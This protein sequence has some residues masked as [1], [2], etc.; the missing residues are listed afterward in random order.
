ME[1]S[2]KSISKRTVAMALVAG[3][4]LMGLATTANA[5]SYEVKSGDTLSS[6][7]VAHDTSIDKLLQTN[8]KNVN[9]VLYVGD[10]LTINNDNETADTY[11]I[12]SGDSLS[13]IAHDHNMT[14]VDLLSVNPTLSAT[15]LILPGQVI[16]LTSNSSVQATAPATTTVD[17]ASAIVDNAPVAQAVTTQAVE[18]V[19]T[20]Q[21]TVEAQPVATNT[22]TTTSNSGSVYDQFIS[23]GGTDALWNNIVMPESG[24]NPDASNGQYHGL[25]QTN[26]SWGSGDVASQTQGMIDYAVS[27]YGSIDNAINVRNAQN[28]W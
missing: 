6:I 11:T 14:L 7:A 21:T 18:P 28:W 1:I 13:K 24:G 17:R 27:R 20:T 22:A 5:D 8:H 10:T 9:D 2:T 4:V 26:Q 15:S 16:N 25:G 23:A 19:A 3:S 12:K